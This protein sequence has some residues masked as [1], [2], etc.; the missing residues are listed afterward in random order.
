M[1]YSQARGDT[2][3]VANAPFD[4]VDRPDENGPDWYKD[5]S[6]LPLAMEIGK[7]LLIAR[8]IAFLYFRILRPLLR[9]VVRKFDEATAI[10]E[11]EKKDGTTKT[12]TPLSTSV[13]SRCWDRTAC[14]SRKRKRRGSAV[15]APTW[16]WQRNG[17]E[18]SAHRGKRNQGMGGRGM[19]D[20]DKDGITKAAILM[21]AMGESEAAEVMKFL[22]PREVLKLG[23]R[24]RR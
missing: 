17:A 6:N 22:G 23:A 24:W 8:V 19:S 15:T 7:Y 10:P 12:R 3:N 2:M 20:K 18:R 16:R 11:E 21:L 13:A 5:P 4:G 1:G 14:R 9:P